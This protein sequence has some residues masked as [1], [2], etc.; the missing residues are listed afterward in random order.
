MVDYLI[1]RNTLTA[2]ADGVRNISGTTEEYTPEEMAAL[3]SNMSPGS[4]AA[5]LFTEQNLTENQ[6]NQARKNIDTISTNDL[7]LSVADWSQDDEN[8]SN[9]IK[10]KPS[11]AS[12]EDIMDFMSELNY[13]SPVTTANGSILTNNSGEI[14]SL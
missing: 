8:A 4:S 3:M 11:I 5:V 10:N 13:I 12:D 9:Y 14:Y 1:K 2:I 7:E 6:K